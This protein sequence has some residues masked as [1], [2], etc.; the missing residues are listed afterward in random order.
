MNVDIH[1][2]ICLY[3]LLKVSKTFNLLKSQSRKRLKLCGGSIGSDLSLAMAS[4]IEIV[5]SNSLHNRRKDISSKKSSIQR[6]TTYMV[7][8]SIMQL[9]DTE[10]V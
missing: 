9:H 4:E 2:N 1:F 3:S 8:Q 7:L 10:N 5:C 6:F